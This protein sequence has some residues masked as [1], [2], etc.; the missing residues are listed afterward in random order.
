MAYELITPR[1]GRITVETAERAEVLKSRGYKPVEQ[2][3]DEKPK[4]KKPAKKEQ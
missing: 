2:P 3:K 4:S 1:G